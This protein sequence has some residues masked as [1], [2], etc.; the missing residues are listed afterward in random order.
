[1][2]IGIAVVEHDGRYLVGTRPPDV[3]L[4]GCAEFPGGKC[5]P[6]E[7]PAL[8]ACRECR[9]ETGLEIRVER[10]LLRRQFDY[11]HGPLELHF[12]LCRLVHG[13]DAAAVQGGFRWVPAAELGGLSFPEA[14]AQVVLM[15]SGLETNV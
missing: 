1:M 12:W 4:A 7:D 10:L 14:N 5:R 9:E 13:T 6:G 15:L 8:C 11:S 2:P 3:P